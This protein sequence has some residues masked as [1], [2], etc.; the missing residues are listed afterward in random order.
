[1]TPVKDRQHGEKRRQ[2]FMKYSS[3]YQYYFPVQLGN[4]HLAARTSTRL[5]TSRYVMSIKTSQPENSFRKPE[6]NLYLYDPNISTVL[7]AAP[8]FLVGSICGGHIF[9]LFFTMT[10]ARGRLFAWTR[11]WVWDLWLPEKLSI[12]IKPHKLP[13]CR[14]LLSY[15]IWWQFIVYLDS[16]LT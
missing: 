10:R 12:C 4:H 3:F 2:V 5:K 16:A 7:S 15:L 14:T 1:M 6:G 8:C 9:K 11:T 13:T